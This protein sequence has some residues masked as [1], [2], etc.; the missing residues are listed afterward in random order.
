MNPM[1]WG[2]SGLDLFCSSEHLRG[3]RAGYILLGFTTL[4][5][6]GWQ[7]E[8][9]DSR[10]ERKVFVLWHLAVSKWNWN[11]WIY[12]HKMDTEEHP[13]QFG[14]PAACNQGVSS[15]L[16][17]LDEGSVF[18]Q[19]WVGGTYESKGW[20][21]TIHLTSSDGICP[22]KCDQSPVS[23]PDFDCQNS[24]KFLGGS[25]HHPWL[26]AWSCA[27]EMGGEEAKAGAA[28]LYAAT[29]DGYLL[30]SILLMLQKSGDHQLRL[31]VY[32]KDSQG[33][34]TS[35]R[36]FS[37]PIPEFAANFLQDAASGGSELC[38]DGPFPRGGSMW[39]LWKSLFLEKNWHVEKRS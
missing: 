20:A 22:S 24:T 37:R 15:H 18:S 31:V 35:K 3:H 21:S 30:K 11:S 12:R 8:S 25:F 38:G 14:V 5:S 4:C 13:L 28:K 19:G 29:S 10:L 34:Y 6:G 16:L 32:P 2:K 36:W 23:F 17:E 1:G 39:V 33:F 26:V 7:E 27:P 9:N